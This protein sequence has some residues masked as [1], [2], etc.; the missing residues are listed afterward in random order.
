[1]SFIACMHGEAQAGGAGAMAQGA[2]SKEGG[3][4]LG[5]RE[6]S[7]GVSRCLLL[8]DG[9]VCSDGCRHLCCYEPA[10]GKMGAVKG[11]TSVKGIG[12]H[13]VSFSHD[14]RFIVVEE[15]RNEG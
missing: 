9:D 8:R 6:G 7:D 5:V 3:P 1:M 15:G 10:V 4:R 12:V 14:G 2:S 13:Q 11:R